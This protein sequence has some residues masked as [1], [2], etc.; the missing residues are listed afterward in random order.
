M[1]PGVVEEVALCLADQDQGKREGG[2]QRERKL[3]SAPVSRNLESA[4][5]HRLSGLLPAKSERRRQNVTHTFGVF[6][7]SSC[8][9][10]NTGQRIVGDRHGQPVSSR[11]TWSRLASS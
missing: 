1:G 8:S 3:C 10:C 6:Q 9:E 11:S 4:I 7:N 5:R 2:K